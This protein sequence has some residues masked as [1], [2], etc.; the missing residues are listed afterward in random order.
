[1]KKRNI[2]KEL[3]KRTFKESLLYFKKVMKIIYNI[4]KKLFAWGIIFYGI[5]AIFSPL[6]VFLLGRIVNDLLTLDFSVIIIGLLIIINFS[7]VII[8]SLKQYYNDVFYDRI[9]C[10]VDIMLQEKLNTLKIEDFQNKELYDNINRS[11]NSLYEIP[12]I[13]EGLLYLS[14]NIIKAMSYMVMI[15]LW[16]WWIFIII[17][18]VNIFSFIKKY[19]VMKKRYVKYWHR[20]TDQRKASYY[21]Y[22]M[23]KKEPMT[24]LKSL[25]AFQYI[26]EKYK[27][28]KLKILNENISINRR[29][30]NN[31]ISL[32]IMD[33]VVATIFFIYLIVQTLA[34]KILV[35]DLYAY[36]S[37]IAHISEAMQIAT[38]DLAILNIRLLNAKEL[39]DF[40]EFDNKYVDGIK[41]LKKIDT[42]EFKNVWFKYQNRKN[43]ALKEINLV[44][45]GKEKIAFIG[46]NGCGKTTIMKLLMKI[47]TPTKGKIL[48]NGID[49][50][51]YSTTSLRDKITML[52]QEITVYEDTVRE[53]ITLDKKRKGEDKILSSVPSKDFRKELQNMSKGIN[54]IL[55]SWFGDGND[56]SKGQQQRLALARIFNRADNVLLLD[57]PNSAL[58]PKAEKELFEYIIND[59]SDKTC[60]LTLHVFTNI[61]QLDRVIMFEKGRIV[62]DGKHEDLYKTSLKYKEY[63]N[64]QENSD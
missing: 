34:Q 20:T 19:K 38:R 17:L 64:L 7:W 42:I 40:L 51:E 59:Q 50:K 3:E 58:D 63:Y 61:D 22:I 46:E 45:K 18:L 11:S 44:I 10:R 5:T 13:Y 4:D 1:M 55:G 25:N 32:S 60:I 30:R 57:E 23:Q 56:I 28:I 62:A 12:H 33:E 14:N 53:N 2:E 54:T 24:E 43:Y 48:I 37:S 15:I 9:K 26:M 6:Q 31:N 27:K 49:I 8:N 36:R 16:Q 41:K 39:I 29:E 35:G 21:S 52:F 47:H